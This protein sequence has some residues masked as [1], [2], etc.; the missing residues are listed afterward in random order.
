MIGDAYLNDL[1]HAEIAFW[2]GGL[3]GWTSAAV[4]GWAIPAATIFEP[5]GT[6]CIPHAQGKRRG[7]TPIA[8]MVLP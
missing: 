8:P 6:F 7:L 3:A 2:Q 5:S 1:G 4:E